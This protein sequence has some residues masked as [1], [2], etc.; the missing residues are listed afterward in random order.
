MQI[1]LSILQFIGIGLLVLLGVLILL[2]GLILFYPICYKTE[3]T[4]EN[5]NRVKANVSWLFH[6]VRAKLIYEDDLIFAE[7]GIFWKTIPFSHESSPKEENSVGKESFDNENSCEDVD[8]T[9]N[10]IK[11]K[12]TDGTSSIVGEETAQ[13]SENEFELEIEDL[14]L[15]EEIELEIQDFNSDDDSETV[16]NDN[17]NAKVHKSEKKSTSNSKRKSKKKK[18]KKKQKPSILE[19]IKGMISKIKG[20]IN[21]G[22]E[23][24]SEVK[25]IL[26]DECNKLAVSHVKDEIFS[27]LKVFLPK[28]SKVDIVFSLG[29][30]DLTGKALGLYFMFPFLYQNEW[31][32]RP[33]FETEE[34]YVKGKFY[35]NGRIYLYKIVGIVLRVLFDKN[36]RR[37]YKAGKKFANKMG[38]GGDRDG[39]G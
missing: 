7:V 14:N 18:K 37:L 31:N 30:P 34:V 6:L 13:E 24:W 38:L 9:E 29:S 25:A 26:T 21:K 22:R 4:F 11:R 33:D 36:C 3:G 16:V 23:I 39:R 28:N 10:Q 1:V 2:L 15:D 8:K 20:T 27:L 19:K 5:E 35:A 17:S 32:V 12:E